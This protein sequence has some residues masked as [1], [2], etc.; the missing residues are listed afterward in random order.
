MFDPLVLLFPP[1]NFCK[2]TTISNKML[3][4]K[5]TIGRWV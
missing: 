1:N 3:A 2:R 5:I 4:A